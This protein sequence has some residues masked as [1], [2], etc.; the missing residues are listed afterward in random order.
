MKKKELFTISILSFLVFVSFTNISIA[1]PPSYA[2]VKTGDEFVWTTSLNMV[3]LNTTGIA[4]FGLDNWTFMYEFFLEYMENAT[5][6]ETPIIT[7]A[8]MKIVMQNVSDELT[9]P[10][11][12]EFVASGLRFDQYLA[13]TPNNW[14]LVTEAANYSSPMTYIIDPSLLNESN[15]WSGFGQMQIFLPIGF[16]FTMFVNVW[17]SRITANPYLNGNVTVQVQGNGFKVTLN[18]VYLEWVYSNMGV[19]FEIGT[20]SDA[21]LTARWNSNGVADFASL[22]YGGLPLA[23]A[24]LVTSEDEGIPGF[25]LVTIIGVSIVTLLAI[26]YVKRKRNI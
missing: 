11:Y 20:L 14:I 22:E 19:P 10:F 2:G 25:E 23:T 9:H 1:A 12:P 16:D 8:G 6:M 4:L 21:V 7:G 18:A 5:G 24:Q 17:S 26:I 3:N 13:Y 15:I